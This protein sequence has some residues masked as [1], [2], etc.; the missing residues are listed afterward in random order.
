MFD[1][2]ATDGSV[3]KHQYKSPVPGGEGEG[4]QHTPPDKL[5]SPAMV[6][7]HRGLLAY[8][9]GELDRQ[10]LNRIERAQ[11]DDYYDNNQW[12]SEDEKVVEERGQKALV[13]NVIASSVDWV[14]NTEKRTAKDFKVLPRKKDGAKPAQRKTELLKYFSDVNHSHHHSSLAFED[15]V[16][17][18]LGWVEDGIQDDADGEII[19]SRYADWREILHDSRSTRFDLDDARYLFRSKWVDLDIAC[20]IFPKRRGLLT[21]SSQEN[22]NFLGLDSYGDEVMDHAELE[23]YGVSARTSDYLHSYQRH[24]LR[25]IE[26]WL[27]IPV[28]SQRIKGGSFHG[29]LFDA[30]SDGHRWSLETENGALLT[31]KV[32]M[33]MHCAMFTSAGMLWFSESPYRHNRFPYTPVWGKRR[34][35]D[36]QPYGMIRGLKG[37]QD[38]INKRASKALYILSTNKVVMDD[39]ALPD[40]FTI[41]DLREEVA[42]PDGIIIKRRG[43]EL[44]INVDRDL[45]QYQLELMGRSIQMVQQASGVTDELLGRRTNAVSGRAIERRQDQGSLATAN[46]FANY[47]LA[48]QLQ[49]EKQLSLIE[50]FV[51]DEKE[52]RI[53]NARG[54]PEYVTVNDGAA[55]NDIVRTKADFLIEESEYHTTLR[56]AAVT[57]LVDMLSKIGNPQ[58]Q[59]LMLDL[60]I[61]NM[62]G[63]INRDEIVKRIRQQT[64]M[65]DPDSSPEDMS[66]EEQQQEAAKQQAQELQTRA[67]MAELATKEAQAKKLLADGERILAQVAEIKARITKTNVE[68]ARGALDVATASLSVAPAAVH[69]ADKVLEE[70]GYADA[71]TALPTPQP[72]AGALEGAPGLAPA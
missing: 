34:R 68:S 29:E 44:S 54:A 37:M 16:R 55:E 43:S 56:Q 25:I 65:R 27:R 12:A 62:D 70:A 8:F 3:R 57:E 6:E 36:G 53:T 13:Y 42:R 1:L 58:L 67:T 10:Y 52:F 69:T 11:D 21:E 38:D 60:V 30:W 17:S 19:Y 32:D 31:S 45:S 4:P 28:M 66:P 59:M 41:D 5:D 72:D 51:T 47:R 22:L 24:R 9:V 50:Q 64:G 39:N 63:L 2:Q 15:A 18:G 46:Y 40:D 7:M 20:A 14:T 26:A 71:S 61:E 49:G 23:E 35:R 33:R 48:K